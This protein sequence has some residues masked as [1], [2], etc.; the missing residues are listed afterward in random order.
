MLLNDVLDRA[1]Q[2][3]G[4]TETNSEYRSQARVYV[5]ATLQDIAA[6]ATWWW[7]YEEASI[8]TVASQ[9]EYVLA[10]NV[11]HLLSVRDETNDR[12]LLIVGSSEID[13]DDPDQSRTGDAAWVYV[14][15]TD[16][17][18]G[19]PILEL[20]PTPDTS[21]ETIKYRYYKTFPELT[22]AND[23]DDLL[24][25]HG[26]PLLLHHALYMGAAAGIMVEYGDDTSARLN[27][28][29]M[30][31]YVRQAKEING[32]MAGNRD[33]RLRRRDARFRLNFRIEEGSLQ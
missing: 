13:A 14:A 5:N 2:R 16:A 9:R 20:H 27:G 24:Q 25:D 22:S 19:A 18:T 33:Y 12:P 26:I 11:Q 8:T 31:R 21:G 17:S 15:G 29:E 4:L 28:G 10:S 1:I 30:E 32:R 6:R 7:M 3:A 23:T